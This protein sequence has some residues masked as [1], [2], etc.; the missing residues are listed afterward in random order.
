MLTGA[1]IGGEYAAINSV[2][3]ELV[4]A[5]LRGRV[6]LWINA[7]FWLGIMLGSGVSV[8]LLS[9]RMLGEALGW[10]VAFFVGLPI[11]V[12]VLLMRRSIPESP[13]WLVTHGRADEAERVVRGVEL[14]L[15][16]SG[17]GAALVEVDRVTE[18]SYAA[19]LRTLTGAYR[20]RS[21]LCLCLM[22]AQ[23]FLYNSVFFS[24]ALVLMR[25]YGVSENRVGLLFVP[26]ALANFLGPT[27]LGPLFDLV[28]RRSMIFATY[29]L[30]GGVLLVADLLFFTHRLTLASQVGWWVAL[31]F[32]ASTAASSA[33]LTVSEVFP[34]PIR[35]SAI[36]V[37]YTFGTVFGGVFGP[38]VFGRLTGTGMRGAIAIGYAAG[39]AVM[40]AAGAAQAVWGVAA[41]GRPL[42]ELPLKE[43]VRDAAVV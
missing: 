35:A 3:D 37:F 13:R 22:A 34:Q 30:S 10:R 17:K 24:L 28:G 16:V 32:F 33:Y 4:P 38:L 5:R 42:E 20:G 21:A 23:A 27:V 1:G 8:G 7:T 18:S 39:G 25:F 11:G 40:I 29:C 14:E 36:A 2:V 12:A 9:P 31:F 6:D 43:K 41:E 19:T 15:G 26:I